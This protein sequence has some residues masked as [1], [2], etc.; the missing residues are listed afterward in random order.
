VVFP[1]ALVAAGHAQTGFVSG[2]LL[3]GGVS[4]VARGRPLAGGALLG[5]LIVKPHLAL[6]V[7]FW[8]AAGGKWRAFVAAGASAVGLLL[9]AWLAFGSETMLAYTGSWAASA[10]IMRSDDAEFYLRMATVY[11]QLRLVTGPAAALAANVVVALAMVALIVLAWRRSG[12]DALATGALMLAAT[13]LAS[14]YL[15]NYDLPFLILP[16]LWLVQRGLRE[17]FRPW[18]K[19][20]LVLLYLAPYATRAAALPLGLNLMPLAAAVL[21]WCVWTRIKK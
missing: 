18:E 21:V 5:A 3:V 8:L 20:G 1:G 4:L 6:L 19:A 7:P 2:A 15:F 11:G 10:A 12:G 13:A 9:A 17:G 14:P 16:L